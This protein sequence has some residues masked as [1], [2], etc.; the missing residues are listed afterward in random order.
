MEFLNGN[1]ANKSR[2]CTPA[3]RRSS[4]TKYKAMNN[5]KFVINLDNLMEL[6]DGVSGKIEEG[7]CYI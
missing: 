6:P 4:I 7:G 2:D 1:S 3:S 5:V